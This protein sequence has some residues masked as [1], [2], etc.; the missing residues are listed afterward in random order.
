MRTL[1]RKLKITAT[2]LVISLLPLLSGC[3]AIVAASA[4]AGAY[5]YLKGNLDSHI[6][7]SVNE[8]IPAI[9]EAASEMNL[10]KIKEVSDQTSARFVFR[11][12]L[13]IKTTITL[14]QKQSNL[15][16]ISIRVGNIGDEAQ[17]ISLLNRINNKL[18]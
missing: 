6:A 13:D 12:S 18:Q 8:A 1:S 10:I 3:V 14:K 7:A 17:S 11:D 5:A 15:T 16:S 4:G 9:Q 2:I